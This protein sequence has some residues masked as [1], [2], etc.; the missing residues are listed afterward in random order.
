MPSARRLVTCR[1]T[2]RRSRVSYR[3]GAAMAA[4]CVAAAAKGKYDSGGGD[5]RSHHYL[6]LS[7]IAG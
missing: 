3:I 1:L 7:L 2:T 6:R 5:G 4:L